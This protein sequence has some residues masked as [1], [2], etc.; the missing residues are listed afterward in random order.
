MALEELDFILAPDALKTPKRKII[1]T[2]G[3]G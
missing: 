2:Q 1:P 3:G